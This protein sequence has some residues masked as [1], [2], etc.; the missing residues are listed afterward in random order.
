MKSMTARSGDLPSVQRSWLSREVRWS[1]H[2][3]RECFV[4]LFESASW[5][6]AINPISTI[7]RNSK[8]HCFICCNIQNSSVA[9]AVEGPRFRK[10]LC[11]QDEKTSRRWGVRLRTQERKE[12][13]VIRSPLC[14]RLF[15]LSIFWL[16]L[17]WPVS[18]RLKATVTCCIFLRVLHESVIGASDKWENAE[19]T[20]VASLSSCNVVEERYRTS[21]QSAWV[22]YSWDASESVLSRW[23]YQLLSGQ[24]VS[25]FQVPWLTL[26][27]RCD[28][29]VG[30]AILSEETIE[31]HFFC[32]F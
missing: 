20:L 31:K 17:R 28:P 30:Y 12:E 32:P 18:S 19:I 15:C 25:G 6:H 7:V 21:R 14:N 26:S 16:K 13:H 11:D 10:C 2:Q 24:N 29:P 3:V 4:H 23:F 8:V 9:F 1:I 22:A 27:R 5:R